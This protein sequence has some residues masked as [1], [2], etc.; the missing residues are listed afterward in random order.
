MKNLANSYL[1]II[2]HFAQL[3]PVFIGKTL[4]GK[5]PQRL[6]EQTLPQQKSNSRGNAARWP[7]PVGGL[8]WYRLLTLSGV[9]FSVGVR[10]SDEMALESWL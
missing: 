8:L 2:V 9:G 4:T 6:G 10:D 1:C 5:I 3:K 7:H